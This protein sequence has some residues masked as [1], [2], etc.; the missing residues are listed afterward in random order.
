MAFEPG[1]L[2]FVAYPKDDPLGTPLGTL[3]NAV[4]K[5]VT[6]EDNGIGQGSFAIHP[7]DTGASWCA[8]DNYVAVWRDSVAGSRGVFV[9]SSRDGGKSFQ[10]EKLG[11][12]TW[13]MPAGRG[14][15]H[16]YVAL[17]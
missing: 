14:T 16:G 8:Q 2:V 6:V 15:C 13:M 11:Y 9:T 1:V 10:A 5:S 7:D 4:R 12:G 17:V 3:T